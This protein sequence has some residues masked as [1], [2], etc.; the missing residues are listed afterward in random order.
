[1]ASEELQWYF[2]HLRSLPAPKFLKRAVT[3]D[4]FR[5]LKVTEIVHIMDKLR[6]LARENKSLIQNYYV[7]YLRGCHSRELNTAADGTF[8]QL[9]GP[10]L[11]S[12]C[13]SIKSDVANASVNFNFKV[14]FH[15]IFNYRNHST[16]H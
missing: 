7:E 5:D 11:E 8:M 12:V 6:T 3:E 1:M 4:E 2:R 16:S 9:V 15:F 10:I 13:Q 14:R